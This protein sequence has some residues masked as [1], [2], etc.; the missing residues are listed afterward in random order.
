MNTQVN[1]FTSNW[2]GVG[3]HSPSVRDVLQVNTLEQ[4]TT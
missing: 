1:K 2:G 4:E 3:G